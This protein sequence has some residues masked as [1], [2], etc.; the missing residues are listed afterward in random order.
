MESTAQSADDNYYNNCSRKS[1]SNN[2]LSTCCW[3]SRSK[4]ALPDAPLPYNLL[5]RCSPDQCYFPS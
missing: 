1:S 4:K 3:R 5:H 2:N